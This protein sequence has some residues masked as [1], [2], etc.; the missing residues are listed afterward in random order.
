[1]NHSSKIQAKMMCALFALL[2]SLANSRAAVINVQF[3]WNPGFSAFAS[4]G[5]TLSTVSGTTLQLG[6]FDSVPTNWSALN[7]ANLSSAFSSLAQLSY[8]GAGGYAFEGDYTAL[9]TDPTVVNRG[10]LVITSG[11]DQLGIFGWVN[12]GGSVFNLPRDPDVAPADLAAV[13]TS[14]GSALSYIYNMTALVGSVS[15]SGV[16]LASASGSSSSPQNITFGAIASKSKGDSFTLSATA[17]SGLAVTYVSSNP[18]VATISGNVVSIVGAGDV[19]ITAS[20]PGNGSFSAAADV[21]QSFTAYGSTALR[22]A[23]LGTPTLNAG[24]TS[25]TH[26]FVGNPNS[27]YTLE[28][29]NNLNDATWTS[30]TVQ[31]GATGTFTATFTSSG[32]YVNAWKNRMFFRAKN[33]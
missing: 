8:T 3:D 21:T 5:A 31:T 19:V 22:L 10:F 18:S 24:S 27:T 32:D 26:T 6:W 16:Q 7:R 4:S 12:G 15:S 14:F 20:Q 2:A 25:V 1:M 28:Y 33:S 9:A 13:D 11:S 23:S 29:K 17:S 30:I